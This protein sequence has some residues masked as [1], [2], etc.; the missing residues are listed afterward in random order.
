[1]K[2]L[3]FAAIACSVAQA[4][5]ANRWNE[6]DPS[7]IRVEKLSD[8]ELSGLTKLS[9]ARQKALDA[10]YD[11]RDAYQKEKDQLQQK[12]QAYAERGD[13]N[14]PRVDVEWKG[15][16]IIV[17]QYP[18]NQAVWGC[19]SGPYIFASPA[20]G[21]LS[22]SLSPNSGVIYNDATSIAK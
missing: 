15:K 4:Q 16:Y 19:S 8:S 13:C 18:S 21:N 17:E 7:N 10:Y 22:G 14:K 6:P 9:D 11:A 2:W 12:Y 3:I 5:S 1:M 20:T